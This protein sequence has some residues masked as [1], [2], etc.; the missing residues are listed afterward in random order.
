[1]KTICPIRFDRPCRG[2]CGWWD[3]L[4]SRCVVVTI[5][6]KLY[7]LNINIG[8]ISATYSKIIS[9]EKEFTEG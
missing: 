9:P 5:G 7:D 6:A 8:D 4:N 2:D 1:M 3:S